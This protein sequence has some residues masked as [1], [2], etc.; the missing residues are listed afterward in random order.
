MGLPKRALKFRKKHLRDKLSQEKRVKKHAKMLKKHRNSGGSGP[1]S[2]KGIDPKTL[3]S[4]VSFDAPKQDVGLLEEVSDTIAE[5]SEESSDS[6]LARAEEAMCYRKAISAKNE[7]SSENP[8]DSENES[9][10]NKVGNDAEVCEGSDNFDGFANSGSEAEA[11]NLELTTKVINEW[12]LKLS[13]SPDTISDVVNALTTKYRATSSKAYDH[14]YKLALDV[15]PLVIKKYIPLENGRL[16]EGDLLDDLYPDI[17]QYVSTL[18]D[19]LSDAQF[20]YATN[21][22]KALHQVTPYM[23]EGEAGLIRRISKCLGALIVNSTSSDSLRM[24][25]YAIMR[26]FCT[27]YKDSFLELCL[28]YNYE[29]LVQT[30]IRVTPSKLPSLNMAKNLFAMLYCIDSKL[31]Y[32]TAFAQL[33]KLALVLK[34][35]LNKAKNPSMDRQVVYSWQ[36]INPLDLF[37]RIIN[38]AVG[39]HPDGT[40]LTHLIHPLVQ[41]MLRVATLVPTAEYF[42]LRFFIVRSLAGLSRHTGVYIP[43]AA[44]LIDVLHSSSLSRRG[45]DASL[46]QF[47]FETNIRAP[48]GYIGTMVYQQG[49]YEELTDLFA[50]VFVLYTKSIAFPE[51]A[52]PVVV[53][54]KRHS[55]ETRNVE[56][57]KSL[58]VLIERLQ[59]NSEYIS[60][61]RADVNFGPRDKALVDAFLKEEPWEKTPFGYFAEVRRKVREERQ[62]LMAEQFQHE[63]EADFDDAESH[64]VEKSE[65]LESDELELEPESE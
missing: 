52:A 46:R 2:S 27:D 43:L 35:A 48:Q 34:S 6:E 60:K 17:E 63:N 40:P 3:R 30:S 49:V 50:E 58:R 29:V 18:L 57:S 65:E 21:A 51:L 28:K 41:I 19:L 61:A 32:Q 44:V 1:L 36:F 23:L 31:G 10:F 25:A 4:T 39:E 11:E 24:E 62:R 9:G 14:L 12:A 5:R 33:R 45:K 38:S 64:V 16:A 56:L 47:D 26:S 42:P 15:L 59:A 22:L 37:V 54:L 53:A 55:R 13:K 8:S 20:P 7:K